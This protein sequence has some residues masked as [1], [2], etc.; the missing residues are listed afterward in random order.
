[1]ILSLLIPLHLFVEV[2]DLQ[3]SSRTRRVESQSRVRSANDPI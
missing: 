2:E 3:V 1:M